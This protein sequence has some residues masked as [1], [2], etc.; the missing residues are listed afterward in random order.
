[1]RKKQEMAEWFRNKYRTDEKFRK[2][3]NDSAKKWSKNNRKR[4]N[5][6]ARKLY[7]NLDDQKKEIRLI[8]IRLMREL[9][10]WTS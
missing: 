6:N 2:K 4:V 5:T 7:A 9:R 8:K 1:M 3:Y 10:L